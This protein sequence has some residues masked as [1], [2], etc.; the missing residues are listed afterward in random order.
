MWGPDGEIYD[1][2]FDFDED[3]ELDAYEYDVMNEVMFG[4]D[5]DSDDSDDLEDELEDDLE[6][7]LTAAGLDMIEL[8]C[9]D[10]DERRE[11]LENAGLDPDDYD[12]Y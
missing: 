12:F 8:E 11:A 5:E 1:A 2:D 3:G 10:E 4:H 9:M 6:D 7:E